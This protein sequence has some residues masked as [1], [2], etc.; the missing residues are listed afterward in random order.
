MCGV[1]AQRLGRSWAVGR[2]RG[3]QD[4]H[5]ERPAEQDAVAAVELAEVGAVA[6]GCARE[7]REAQSRARA[8]GDQ[9]VGEVAQREAAAGNEWARQEPVGGQVSE[10]AGERLD[11]DR[12]ERGDEAALE[13]VLLFRY[14]AVGRH[15]PDPAAGAGLEALERVAGLA[16]ARCAAQEVPE[17][18]EH[19][20]VAPGAR[21]ALGGGG[22]HGVAPTAGTEHL[23]GAPQLAP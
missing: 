22:E 18:R 16:A 11:R 3:R 9:R 5:D 14:A 23:A 15:G 19:E 20:G 12:G 6:E 1:S 10:L 13:V 8:E 2:V 4:R 21:L 17:A 7:L